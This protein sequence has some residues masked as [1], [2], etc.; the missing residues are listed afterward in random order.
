MRR[1]FLGKI[2]LAIIACALLPFSTHA[3]R[4]RGTINSGKINE[5]TNIINDCER[6]TNQFR[7][8]LDRALG[9]DNV[10]AG[11]GRENQLNREATQLHD[12]MART[13][14]AWNRD[15]N[16]NRARQNVNA[17]IVFARDIDRAMHNW[18]MGGDAVSQWAAVRSELN[19][20]AL[21]LGLPKI[22]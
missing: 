20:L 3:Q 11:Q 15:H 16:Y 17:A 9:R 14:D 12:A 8:T 1:Q 6:R 2:L 5:T 13:G 10:R 19:R 21:N 22:W 7:K 4:R 18:N